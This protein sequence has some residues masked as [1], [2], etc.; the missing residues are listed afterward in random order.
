MVDHEGRR[1]N[2]NLNT[3]VPLYTTSRIKDSS[4]HHTVFQGVMS[5]SLTH[6]Y[7]PFGWT[8]CLHLEH[9]SCMSVSVD[10]NTWLHISETVIPLFLLPLLYMSAN[11]PDVSGDRWWWHSGYGTALQIGRSL[12]QFQMMSLEF[13][14]DI[15]LPIALWPWG[16]LSL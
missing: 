10:Q 5:R 6:R 11:Y 2:S 9:S 1:I 7:Q 3:F 8:H 14:T 4:L 15:I 12:V 13:F 16:R